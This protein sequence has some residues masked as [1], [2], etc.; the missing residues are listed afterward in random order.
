MP[1]IYVYLSREVFRILETN[2]K[3]KRITSEK[4][5]QELVISALDIGKENE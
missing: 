1:T 3:R 4:L 5:A 2:A